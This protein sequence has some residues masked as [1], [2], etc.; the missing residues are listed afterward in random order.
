MGTMNFSY[1]GSIFESPDKL[2][3]SSIL[4]MPEGFL[5]DFQVIQP[6]EK[7]VCIFSCM[8]IAKAAIQQYSSACNY[9]IAL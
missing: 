1:T 2:W 4:L 9:G 6:P 5:E 3:M 8:Q 7:L